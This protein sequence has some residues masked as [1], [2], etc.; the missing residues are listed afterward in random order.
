M[1]FPLVATKVKGMTQD[2]DLTDPV[3]R[4]EYFDAKAGKEVE[5]LKSFMDEH[6][7]VGFLLGKKMSGKG[8][9]SK[10]LAEMVGE[11]RV[12]HFSVGDAVRKVER[13]YHQE[14][15]KEIIEQL[16]RRYRGYMPFDEALK[17]FEN[18]DTQSLIPT[19]FILALIE[20]EIDKLPKK[21]LLIDGFPR[22]MDQV[23]YSLY[24]R[25]LVNY[26]EDPDFF[27]LISI[28]E[29]V[30]NE[31][32][33]YRRVCPKCQTSR[34]LKLL[35]TSDVRYDEK[36][37]E[38]YLWCDNPGCEGAR[39]VG[40]EGDDQ[41]VAMIKERLDKD[42]KLMEM[43]YDLYGVPRIL[44]RNAVPVEFAKEKLDEYELTPEFYF[45][46]DKSGKVT[47]KTRPWVVRD[48]E[49]VESYSL[50]PAPVVLSMMKQMVKLL[51]L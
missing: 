23:S 40:K 35:V 43:A 5:K 7:F 14:K 19:E 1:E 48:D 9:Y 30:I 28:P 10:M 36:K 11:D 24:F 49:G 25:D 51:G 20:M 33:K 17:A 3:G 38:F 32:I 22:G 45:E 50:M 47:V 34:N 15:K 18:R 16:E 37:K 21:S 44:L 41:G 4:H 12:A 42:Q 39:L 2:F 13:E 6:T 31:R 27:V 26:R 29:S 8:T 46:L